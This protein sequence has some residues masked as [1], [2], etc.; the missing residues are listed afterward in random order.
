MKNKKVKQLKP[1]KAPA[2]G[3]VMCDVDSSM[4]RTDS[5]RMVKQMMRREANSIRPTCDPQPTIKK[6]KAQYM[7]SARFWGFLTDGPKLLWLFSGSKPLW[8]IPFD[9]EEMKAEKK[10]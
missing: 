9:E 5:I 7:R 4:G 8:K 2:I 1:K 10:K 6:A 3:Y